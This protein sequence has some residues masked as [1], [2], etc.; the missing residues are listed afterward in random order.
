MYFLHKRYDLKV[1]LRYVNV[2]G[3]LEG[4][5]MSG[6]GNLRILLDCG[7]HLLKYSI[8]LNLYG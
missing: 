7:D 6:T 4:R 8:R 1:L 2:K 3:R 5:T